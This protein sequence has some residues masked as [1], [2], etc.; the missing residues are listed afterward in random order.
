[1]S[2]CI[3]KAP[4]WEVFFLSLLENFTNSCEFLISKSFNVATGNFFSVDKLKALLITL[5]TQNLCTIHSFVDSKKKYIHK[6][7]L[8]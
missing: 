1:M 8:K 2:H 3:L 6:N 4:K 5:L 7:T